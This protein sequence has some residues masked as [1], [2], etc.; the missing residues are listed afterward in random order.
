MARTPDLERR[1]EL[2][3]RIVVYLADHG[4]AQATLRP[5]ARALD[6][7]I[8]RLVHHFGSKE[9]LLAAAMTRAMEQQLEVQAE[10]LQRSPGCTLVELYQ[11]WW[12][13]INASPQN[14]A[15]VR[16][17]YEAAALDPSVTGLTG[18]LRADQIGAWRHDAAQRFEAEGL[19]REQALTE[20]ALAKATF[21]GLAMDL[22]ATGERTRLTRSF[23]EFID[24]LA[25]RL[26]ECR[27]ANS[28]R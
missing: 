5:M 24:R 19:T 6:V 21:T 22:F 25:A 16:L 18:D 23:N 3:D 9:D 15:L 28:P 13:W 2:L 7:S 20:A 8:N 1:Q 12:K 26:D 4:L 11:R 17:N 10:W 14:L 27:A